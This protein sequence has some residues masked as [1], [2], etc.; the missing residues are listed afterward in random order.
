[1]S[2]RILHARSRDL[3]GD[4]VFR[5]GEGGADKRYKFVVIAKAS[6]DCPN[7]LGHRYSAQEAENP[8]QTIS[9][10]APSRA[11]VGAAH[12]PTRHAGARV[13][14]S[15]AAKAERARGDPALRRMSVVRADARHGG[16]FAFGLSEPCVP[17]SLLRTR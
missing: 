10:P 3:P 8:V 7:Y 17:R 14:A 15:A 11:V 1:M 5:R 16:Q 12:G 6:R 9:S 2:R 13:F 4:Q